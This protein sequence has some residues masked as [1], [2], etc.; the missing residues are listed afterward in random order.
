MP[1]ILFGGGLPSFPQAN[2]TAWW[3]ADAIIGLNDGD[4]V[5]TWVDSS[6]SAFDLTG[7]TTA[8]PTFQ[9]NERAGWPI[10]R[11]DG[12][13]DMMATTTGLEFITNSAAT[14]F[15]VHKTDAVP[16]NGGTLFNLKTDAGVEQLSLSYSSA[17]NL[18]VRHYDGSYDVADKTIAASTY[19]ITTMMHTG[20]VSYHGLT[21]T[22]T[23]SMSSI[24]SGN[25]SDVIDTLIEVGGN[26]LGAFEGA[27]I[28]EI[29]IFTAA[30]SEADRQLVEIHLAA[31][32]AFILPY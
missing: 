23:A 20:G 30:L 29:I 14:I 11:F 10:V 31:K 27:D 1:V 3:K 4:A 9:T 32:Y 28:A 24:A 13:D 17:T 26:D 15:I 12:T 6:P 8:K 21:D 7:I 22:R 5:T 16:A 2:M 18:R 19:Y 25:T